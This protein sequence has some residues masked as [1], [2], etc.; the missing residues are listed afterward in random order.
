MRW[1]R[2]QKTSWVSL[3]LGILLGA[4]GALA[5]V[6]LLDE[7][8][9]HVDKAENALRK[10]ADPK[11]PGEYGGHRKRALDA[12]GDAR[13]EIKKAKE[14]ASGPHPKP[15]PPPPGPGPKPEPTSGPKKPPETPHTP[16]KKPPETPPTPPKKPPDAP[17]SPPKK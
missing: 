5:G 10:A 6:S 8:D 17:P 12:L 3:P 11:T 1:S 4:T 2:V 14:Y 15:P 7:A 16:P 13:R 9:E